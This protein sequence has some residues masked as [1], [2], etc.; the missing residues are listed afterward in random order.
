VQREDWHYS[1]APLAE[2]ARHALTP[3]VLREA[4]AGAPLEGKAEVLAQL[5]RLHARYV[6]AIDLP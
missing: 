2:T 6:A 1:F 3:A 4:L 5:D